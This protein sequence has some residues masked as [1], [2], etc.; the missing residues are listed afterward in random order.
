MVVSVLL[1]IKFGHTRI[2]VPKTDIPMSKTACINSCSQHTPFYTM[3]AMLHE[4]AFRVDS[5]HF[6]S[7]NTKSQNGSQD[8]KI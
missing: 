8:I 3:I 6:A 7:G 5:K 1:K 4:L 2:S